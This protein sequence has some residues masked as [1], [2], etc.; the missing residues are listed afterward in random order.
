[1]KCPIADCQEQFDD[2]YGVDEHITQRHMEASC[3]INNLI[4][5]I[6]ESS[7]LLD[8][9]VPK[10]KAPRPRKQHELAIPYSKITYRQLGYFKDGVVE[11][12]SKEQMVYVR[13]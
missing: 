13:W 6:L 9:S 11:L 3:Y 1:M 4:N 10:A 8:E 12:D 5:R 2:V 7:E